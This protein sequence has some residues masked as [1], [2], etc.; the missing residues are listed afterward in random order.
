MKDE[1]NTV[2][3]NSQNKI[4]FSQEGALQNARQQVLRT[5]IQ[6]WCIPILK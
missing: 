2:S 4:L 6:Q 1:E 5:V 3:N